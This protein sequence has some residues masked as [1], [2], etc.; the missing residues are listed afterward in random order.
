MVL[1]ASSRCS[2]GLR[3][4]TILA[5]MGKGSSF[6]F[7]AAEEKTRGKVRTEGTCVQPVTLFASTPP[8]SGPHVTLPCL[9]THLAELLPQ[10]LFPLPLANWGATDG[11]CHPHLQPV[12]L[13]PPL[14][15]ELFA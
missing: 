8:L 1:T 4:Q 10:M 6:A 2:R 7:C 15:D 5:D 3:L 13:L 14:L 9:S 12:C 11:A